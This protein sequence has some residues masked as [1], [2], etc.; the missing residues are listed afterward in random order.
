[1]EIVTNWWPAWIVGIVVFYGWALVLH[2]KRFKNGQLIDS[3][4][5]GANEGIGKVE[6]LASGTPGQA[7][8]T[9]A[10]ATV[11]NVAKAYW[12]VFLCMMVGVVF[13]VLL[14]LSIFSHIMIA[15][16]AG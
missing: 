5:S 9:V 13:S 3:M 8:S 10:T 4:L 1:M 2:W 11:K 6:N 7:L 15:L 12:P 14:G 16:K